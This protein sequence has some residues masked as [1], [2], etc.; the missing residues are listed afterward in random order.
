MREKYY[1]YLA[2]FMLFH[3]FGLHFPCTSYQ[4]NGAC[5]NIQMLQNCLFPNW[6]KVMNNQRQFRMLGCTLWSAVIVVVYTLCA[7]RCFRWY[8]WFAGL[9]SHFLYV[10]VC[11]WAS[12]VAVVQLIFVIMTLF[13]QV[14]CSLFSILTF[15]KN[16]HTREITYA[17]ISSLYDKARLSLILHLANTIF[18]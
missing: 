16:T 1:I 17:V 7:C 8:V 12:L 5:Y 18:A 9:F 14:A 13:M 11:V 10:C 15:N 2:S 3:S 6:C 4:F